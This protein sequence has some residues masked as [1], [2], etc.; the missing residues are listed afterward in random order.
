MDFIATAFGQCL[1]QA[2]NADASL[3]GVIASNEADIATANDEE[4]FGWT[5]Q[6]AIDQGLEGAC[7]INAR[8][9]VAFEGEEF[10]ARPRCY[11]QNFWFDNDVFVTMV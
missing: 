3:Q 7:A 11:Q 9:G 5:D 1:N 2:D 4:L 8:Q 6:V 10:F